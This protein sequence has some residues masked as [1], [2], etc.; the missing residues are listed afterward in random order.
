MQPAAQSQNKGSALQMAASCSRM[1][2]SAIPWRNTFLQYRHD[3]EHDILQTCRA[4][5]LQCCYWQSSMGLCRHCLGRLCNLPC[6]SP[7]D[8]ILACQLRLPLQNLLERADL[9]GKLGALPLSLAPLQQH[10]K[11][12]LR[13]CA[14]R[15]GQSLQSK[16]LE[17]FGMCT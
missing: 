11:V 5:G 2:G 13:Q 6:L 1:H 9:P 15:S 17:M 4:S 14:M 8:G 10:G 3:H 16:G 7:A 12:S